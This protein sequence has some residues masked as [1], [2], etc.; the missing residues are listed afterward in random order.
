MSTPF[1]DRL[2]DGLA[3]A[4]PAHETMVGDPE[5]ESPAWD[6]TWIQGRG[7]RLHLVV[8]ATA[9]DDLEGTLVATREAPGNWFWLAREYNAA[10]DEARRLDA[11]AESHG[12]GVLRVGA[13]SVE[14]TSLP[15]PK[16]GIHIRKHPA[17][18]KRWRQVSSF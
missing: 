8:I 1:R 11:L 7:D 18:R 12:F 3:T 16:P 17:L 2:I 9:H 5:G 15:A 13:S 6:L 14:R 4:L 10:A